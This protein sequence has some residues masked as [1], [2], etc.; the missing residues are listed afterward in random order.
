MASGVPSYVATSG[1]VDANETSDQTAA[2]EIPF[3][4][5]N[6]YGAYELEPAPLTTVPAPAP[7]GDPRVVRQLLNITSA[8]SKAK[9]AWDHA[10]EGAGR[11]NGQVDDGVLPSPDDARYQ[12]GIPPRIPVGGGTAYISEATRQ[13]YRDL[14]RDVAR[15]EYPASFDLI[16]RYSGIIAN[17]GAP[18]IAGLLEVPEALT[19]RGWEIEGVLAALSSLVIIG[20]EKATKS[21]E[22]HELAVT[23]TTGS[24][25]WGLLPYH[26]PV[27]Y[28]MLIQEE[29]AH[30]VVVAELADIR[31]ARGLAPEAGDDQLRVIS[32]PGFNLTTER[33]RAA[34]CYLVEGDAAAGLPPV[35]NLLLDSLDKMHVPETNVTGELASTL[36]FLT[37]LQRRFGVRV[38]FSW[39]VTSRSRFAL[40]SALGGDIIPRWWTGGMLLGWDDRSKIRRI[41]ICALRSRMGQHDLKL[42][43]LGTTDER[44][45]TAAGHWEFATTT[46]RAPAAD[47]AERVTPEAGANTAAAVERAREIFAERPTIT[48]AELQTAVGLSRSAAYRLLKRLREDTP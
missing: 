20:D 18:E 27:G 41:K 40:E 2:A 33:D 24:P 32:Q 48:A 17:T 3:G 45:I 16:E 15:R 37:Q 25:H 42:R 30:G 14:Q 47:E 44:G 22:H 19:T 31:A 7:L 12:H 28:T 34:L 39:P 8:P 10:V 9:E 21:T 29:N 26:G 36:S 23:F 35:R 1:V 4:D 46:T 5:G 38:V 13:A 43:G 11:H 6:G